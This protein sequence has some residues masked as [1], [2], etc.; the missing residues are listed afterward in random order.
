MKNLIIP[1]LIFS[2]CLGCNKK[3]DIE[4]TLLNKNI[5]SY[6]KNISRD[7]INL[8]KYVVRNNSDKTYFINNLIEQEGLTQ[9]AVSKNGINL[10]IFKNNNVE[11]P[12]RV[13]FFRHESDDNDVKYSTL[14]SEDFE[15]T[16][17]PL[18]YKFKFLGSYERQNMF[19]IHPNETV[20]FAYTLNL[21]RPKQFEEV[22]QG[23][24][25]LDHNQKYYAKLSIVS[26]SS[27]YK[28][29]LPKDILETIKFN[30]AKVYN[31]ILTSV[32]KVPV[33]V[34]K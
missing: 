15:A 25:D 17:K 29:V 27:N 33:K 4:L 30:K 10:R 26:D 3:P 20:F 14:L 21:N 8:I 18:G 13:S 1:V 12:Y 24:V 9:K 22:R 16:K 31:G 28:N 6:S 32:N 7:T 2:L 34:L 23:Y 5:V 11:E 19:F